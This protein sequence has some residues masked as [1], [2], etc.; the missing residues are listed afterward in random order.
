MVSRGAIKFKTDGTCYRAYYRHICCYCGE[1]CDT[2]NGH[3][4]CQKLNHKW[5]TPSPS[6]INFTGRTAYN[7]KQSKVAKRVLKEFLE[8][9]KKEDKV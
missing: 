2:R 1:G 6:K 4:V 8:F 9:L 3:R 7:K 5:G